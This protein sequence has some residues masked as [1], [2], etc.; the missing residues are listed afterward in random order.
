MRRPTDL[1]AAFDHWRRRVAGETLPITMEPMCGY[2]RRRLVRGGVWV[3]VAIWLEQEIDP[4]TG[5]L[6]ADE[7]MRCAVAGREAD[8]HEQWTYIAG[9]PIPHAEYEYLVAN[10]KWAAEYAPESPA[11]QPGRKID[12]N[13]LPPVF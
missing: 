8:P 6:L 5:D 4:D 9:Q 10:Q 12:L 11:A 13:S 1:V 2:Y 7:V 3:P